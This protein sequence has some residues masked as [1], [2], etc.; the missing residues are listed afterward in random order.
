MPTIHFNLYLI[1]D[2]KL[3]GPWQFWRRLEKALQAGLPAFQLREKDLCDRDLYAMS[4]RARAL[5][6]RYGCKLL[7]NARFDIA[8]AVE[9]DGVHLPEDSLPIAAVRTALGP[10]ALIGKSTHSLYAA[11]KAQKDG[12]DFITFG[13]VFATASK[14]RFGPPVGLDALARV[15]KKI[16]IPVFALGG[17]REE[18]A[19]SALKQGAKGIALTLRDC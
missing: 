5:T 13:P 14:K 19:A 4:R 18:N 17:I 9:A 1:S 8:K 2:R 12:A 15:C 6:R 11:T 16:T 3:L 7:I 10:R